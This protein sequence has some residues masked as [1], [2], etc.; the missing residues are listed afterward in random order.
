MITSFLFFIRL[1]VAWLATYIA[2]CIALVETVFRYR[3]PSGGVFVLGGFVLAGLVIT[4]A[5]SH[6]RRVRLIAGEIN[7]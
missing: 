7:H 4:G 2:V 1:L 5:F 3:G 6:L